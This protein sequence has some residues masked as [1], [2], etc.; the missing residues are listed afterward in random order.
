MV[1]CFH[2]DSSGIDKDGCSYV[3]TRDYIATM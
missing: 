1:Q 3:A 2:S